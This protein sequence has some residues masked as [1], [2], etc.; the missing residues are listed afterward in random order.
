MNSFTFNGQNSAE[1]GIHISGEGTFNS[2]ELDTTSYSIPGRSGDLVISNGR[3]KNVTVTYPAFIISNFKANAE[4]LRAWLLSPQGYCRLE[5]SYH[6]D[7][8]HM[9]RFSGPLDFN[10]HFLNRS[11][12]CEI[13]FNC[14]PQRFLLSGETAVEVESGDEIANPTLFDALPQIK[15]YGTGN[16]A[17]T[18]GETTVALNGINEFVVLDCDLQNAYKNILNQNS[19]MTG[20]FPKLKPGN[21]II[22]WTGAI[23]KVE[24]TPRWW[25]L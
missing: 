15:V 6:P 8:Y 21:N 18:V 25:T 11:G 12:E 4:A 2:P 1:Y 3:Y 23:T 10:M 14:K 19:I 22:S 13:S 7:M 5:D 16:G 20:S 24:I 17:L 9:A